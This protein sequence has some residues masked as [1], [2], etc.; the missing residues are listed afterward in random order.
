MV[1]QANWW[2]HEGDSALLHVPCDLCGTHD[3]R[4]LITRTDGLDVVQCVGC[5]LAYVSPRPPT[6]VISR[7]YEHYFTAGMSST[8]QRL[9]RQRQ[10]ETSARDRLAALES[11]EVPIGERIL[12]VGCAYGE[13][14]S[15]L[16]ASG[17]RPVGLD[18]SPECVK[19]ARQ[20]YPRLDFRLG[21]LD[22]VLGEGIFDTICA[23]QVIEHYESPS[24]FFQCAARLIKPGGTLVLTTPNLACGHAVGAGNWVGFR[25]FYEHLYFFTHESLDQYGTRHGFSMLMARSTG[26]HASTRRV[27]HRL[28]RVLPF[29]T[30]LALRLNAYRRRRKGEFRAANDL[31]QHNLLVVLRRHSD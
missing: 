10:Y 11:I 15:A 24:C 6:A 22:S 23:F 12:E 2:N 21:N 14:V 8:E 18:I 3:S 17:R 16:L 27:G 19:V 20:R 30:P 13:F 5:G 29:L 31:T 1:S 26:G 28:K 25:R 9:T 4:H 7:L